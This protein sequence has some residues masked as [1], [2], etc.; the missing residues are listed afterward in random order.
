M[1]DAG[2]WW[3]WIIHGGSNYEC[4]TPY[5]MVHRHFVTGLRWGVEPILFL[6]SVVTASQFCILRISTVRGNWIPIGK[7]PRHADKNAEPCK[8]FWQLKAMRARTF[9]V[10][11]I[12]SKLSEA[13]PPKQCGTVGCQTLCSNQWLVPD[14]VRSEH[15][16][17]LIFM[18]CWVKAWWEFEIWVGNP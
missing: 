9:K 11:W 17:Q 15:L 3:W 2:W 1:K 5:W 4:Y 6:A 18:A 7:Y 8:Y 16:S 14:H 13:K 10:V 12:I